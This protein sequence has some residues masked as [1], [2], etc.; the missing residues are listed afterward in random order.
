MNRRAILTFL[1]GAAATLASPSVRAADDKHVTLYKDPQCGCCEGYADYLRA[2]AFE[3]D[4]IPTH[5]LP[6]LYEKYSIASELE[7]CHLSLVGGY[8][9]G[10]HV[11]VEIV[12]RLLAEKPA[13]TGVTLP[14][15]PMGSPGM[16]GRKT[17]PF[18]IYE[19]SKGSQKIYAVV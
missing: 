3:V 16:S 17:A 15:M 2:S 12:S 18:T 7:P 8:V 19:I 14:G 5:D 4:I 6:L 11:P 13:I 10:G 9:V 1:A